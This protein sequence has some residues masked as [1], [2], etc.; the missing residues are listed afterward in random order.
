MSLGGLSQAAAEQLADAAVQGAIDHAFE[1]IN[2][3]GPVP[4]AMTAAK[5][6]QLR[7][8][9]DRAGRLL[10]QREVEILFR[11]PS[12]QARSILTTMGATYEEALREKFVERMRAD[13]TVVASG[14]DTGG[15]T[16]T[17]RFSEPSAYDIGWSE[18]QRLG[19]AGMADTNV[20][21][22]TLIIPR[23]VPSDGK[24]QDTLKLL[25]LEGPK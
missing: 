20:A 4:T 23:K 7:F 11:V 22:R 21:R 10:S 6:N 17:L 14:T 12:T 1:L 16:W 5:A 9:C 3:T 8:I 25:G 24:Q 13:V 18:L 19:L 2:G 15:L